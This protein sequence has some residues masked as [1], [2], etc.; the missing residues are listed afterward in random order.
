M[1]IVVVGANG[2]LGKEICKQL[3]TKTSSLG[4]IPKQMENAQV[5]GTDVLCDNMK[6]LDITDK[7]A[8]VSFIKKEKPDIVI[9]CAAFTN[10]DLCETQSES[11]FNLNSL[12]PRNLARACDK[13]SARLVHV[14]TD[15]VFSGVSDVPFCEYDVPNPQS[16]YGKTK[17]LG[18]KYVETFCK[19]HFIVRT[20]WLYGKFGNNFVKTISKIAAE[21]GELKVVDDQVGNP[22][23]AEDVAYHI[24]KIATTSE[25]GLYNCTGNGICSWYE[26][27][28]KIVELAGINANVSPCTTEEFPRPAKRPAYSAL[29]NNM[30]KLTVGDEMRNWKIALQ[31]YFENN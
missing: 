26:F 2:Q 8:V 4:N 6:N 24:L 13:V 31:S 9:N 10:V 11:A 28:C 15:Y 25:Y 14:S 22:T 18:E 1:K 27:A 20:S 12:G 5:V 7:K 29:E 30:L 16:V 21:K 3:E 17:L 19:K 23:N